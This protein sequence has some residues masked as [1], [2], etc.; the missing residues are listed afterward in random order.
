[1]CRWKR[2]TAARTVPR[3]EPDRALP[4]SPRTWPPR[5]QSS[6]L[7]I[8]AREH[9]N[10]SGSPHEI[11]TAT[12]AANAKAE[13]AFRDEADMGPMPS[14]ANVLPVASIVL[15][16]QKAGPRSGGAGQ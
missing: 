14:P 11:L 13:L 9:A 2:R 1:M 15:F 10:G 12:E 8:P 5:W 7:V 3:A 6:R 4:L 16:Q